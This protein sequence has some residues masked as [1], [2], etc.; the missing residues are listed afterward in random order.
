MIKIFIVFCGFVF[1]ISSS[2]QEVL[3]PVA[4]NPAKLLE[5]QSSAKES[6]D[7]RDQHLFLPFFDDFTSPGP[8][9]DNTL[10]ADS[11]VYVNSSY[12]YH[13]K[14]FGVATFDAL[15][16]YGKI[17]EE[18]ETNLYQFEADNLTSQPIRLDVRVENDTET[19]LTPADSVI[20]SFYYQPQGKGFA[21]IERDSLVLQFLKIIDEPDKLN[22]DDDEHNPELWV[23]VWSKTGETL[24]EF[25]GGEFPY[26]KR[27]AITIE[28]EDYFRE[29]FRFRFKNYASYP[30][31]KTPV[32]YAGNTSIW[33]I[34]YVYLD[35]N[36]SVNDVYY[37]DIAF[38]EP[39][40]S[41]LLNY[42]AMPWSHY[43]ASP[44]TQLKSNFDVVFANLDN[45]IY[46]Y[47]YRY[48]ITDEDGE[49]IRNYSGGSWNIAPF[50]ESGYQNYEPHTSPLVISNPLPTD[51]A[52]ERTFYIKHVI[53]EG[54]Q[55]DW[56][57]RN[58]T[59]VYEQHFSDFYAY[60]DG[61]P[62]GGYGLS[63]W[64]PQG[65]Y[66]FIIPKPDKI[67]S[68]SFFFNHT[69][70]EQNQIPFHLMVWKSL[71]PVEV[72][73]ES[74]VII[75]EYSDDRFGF[76]N[77]PLTEAVN[78]VD[79][80]YVGWAQLNSDFINLGFDFNNDAG[81]NIF[82]NV[83]GNWQQSIYSGAL[84]IRPYFESPVNI[85]DYGFNSE[86]FSLYP[87]PVNNGVINIKDFRSNKQGALIQIFDIKGRLVMETKYSDSVNI[88]SLMPGTYILK[89]SEKGQLFPAMRFI[90]L[91]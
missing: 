3:L 58:D 22:D 66:R 7:L 54:A 32:N 39:A 56:F 64:N 71:D 57:Q 40:Q 90:V 75:P 2:A 61:V 8:Y 41:I 42:T 82:F 68:V 49:L 11:F 85:N 26:L 55:G 21:P 78:V 31:M 91:P 16:Q 12:G 74:E 47:T 18:A 38:V 86:P 20:I 4:A 30:A 63:G 44:Q 50:D 9:P 36:R 33:N 15:D 28:D 1:A 51:E 69:L 53:R 77:F 80:F 87:N 35:A 83:D 29:D 59:I 6:V 23:T 13:P 27:V 14:T 72:L 52:E 5:S 43:I 46:N 89:I 88:I 37:H 67:K 34:D 48:F 10:W 73:Y 81:Q 84:M 24:E 19:P 45:I 70:F 65:A 17:Y 60:D 62:E 25:S 79:T 76:V